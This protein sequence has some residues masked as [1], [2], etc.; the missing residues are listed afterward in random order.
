MTMEEMTNKALLR[1]F[2]RAVIADDDPVY[3][4]DLKAEILSRMVDDEIK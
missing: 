2:A 3:I 1:E 4:D